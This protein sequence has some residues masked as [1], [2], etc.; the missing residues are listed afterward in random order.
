MNQDS[1]VHESPRYFLGWG[2]PACPSLLRAPARPQPSRSQS[3]NPMRAA[4]EPAGLDRAPP[5]CH[6]LEKGLRSDALELPGDAAPS[7]PARSPASPPLPPSSPLA[8][9]WCFPGRAPGLAAA[10]VGVLR[11]PLQ[12]APPSPPQCH[13]WPLPSELSPSGGTASGEGR[14][15]QS[16]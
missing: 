2:S 5:G 8:L 16:E 11:R 12:G 4:P 7:R 1:R 15:A 6:Q 3:W 10:A 9:D 14:S 13:P